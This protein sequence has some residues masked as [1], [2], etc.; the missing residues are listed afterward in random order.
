[1]RRR[2]FIALVGSAAAAWPVA[3][4]AQRAPIRIGFLAAGAAASANSAISIDAIK[5]SYAKMA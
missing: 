3:A 1:M 2:Q 5:Q 4:H